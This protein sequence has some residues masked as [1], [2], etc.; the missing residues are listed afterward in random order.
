MPVSEDPYNV[1]LS[2]ASVCLSVHPSVHYLCVY[3][4]C[5]TVCIYPAALLAWGLLG[6]PSSKHVI[7]F[8]ISSFHLAN[9]RLF[10]II[11]TLPAFFSSFAFLFMPET[12]AF[13]YQV[14]S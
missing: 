7:S 8:Y 9:W 10:L 13:L 6:L 1:C 3:R 12:P 14:A 2:V 5:L 4:I 11:C